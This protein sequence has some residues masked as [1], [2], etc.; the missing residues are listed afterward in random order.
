M[1][2]VGET[3]LPAF[4]LALSANQTASG[5]VATVPLVA[6][7]A[8]QMLAPYAVRRLQSYRLWTIVCAFVQAVAF[9]PLVVAAGL[10]AMPVTVI[11]A[12]ASVYWAAGMATGPAWNAWVETLVPKEI[13]AKFFAR[14]TRMSQIGLLAGFI[15]GG[16]LLQVVRFENPLT[17]FALLFLVAAAA[18]TISAYWLSCQ[19]EPEKPSTEFAAGGWRALQASLRSEVDLRAL[20]FLLA[21]QM[22]VW[23][24]GPY[25]AAYMFVHLELSYAGFM[26]L[27]CMAV[28][29]KIVCLPLFGKAIERW[30][31]NRVLWTSGL[32]I[33]AAPALWALGNGFAYLS[34]VQ[35]LSGAAWGAY[36]LAMLL[37][38]F[39]TIP[40]RS[41]IQVLT[42]FNVASATAIVTGSLLGAAVLGVLGT[43]Q[44]TYMVLFTL[45]AAVRGGSLLLLVRLPRLRFRSTAVATRAVAL[46]PSVGAIERP[47]LPS[48]AVA[49]SPSERG[50]SRQAALH[51]PGA[52]EGLPWE[53]K[54]TKPAPLPEL[55][56]SG[57]PRSPR[58]AALEDHDRHEPRRIPS[59]KRS[60]AISQGKTALSTKT[61]TETGT[62]A[63][64][65]GPIDSELGEVVAAW[66]TLPRRTRAGILAIVRGKP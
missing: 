13:R 62:L 24:A 51:A 29:A 7:A 28:V 17:G 41:R 48:L 27:A 60:Q 40:R 45:S 25:F 53:T 11:F 63:A 38:F 10:G 54:S 58:T 14:R 44:G 66:P 37:V 3:Y 34:C 50:E 18:R 42:V 22:G 59:G 20:L 8:L 21:M 16:L 55:G 52:M 36:E 43:G 5:L 57:R 31:A 26:I 46:G 9:L 6:G 30:G 4:V 12:V 56:H 39:D 1:V 49:D 15:V 64:E 35:V 23:I 33:A 2:G 19:R 32:V 61:G 47:I 65:S